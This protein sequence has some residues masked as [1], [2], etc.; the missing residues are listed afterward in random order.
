MRTQLHNQTHCEPFWAM[1]L[2]TAAGTAVLAV[3]GLLLLRFLIYR[4]LGMAHV[5]AAGKLGACPRV[6]RC[7]CVPR[8]QPAFAAQWW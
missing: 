8:V 7:A 2:V 1:F 3:A 5:P 6:S 4:V